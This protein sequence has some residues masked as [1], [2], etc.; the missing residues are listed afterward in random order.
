MSASV[1]VRDAERTVLGT[2]LLASLGHATL[3][4]PHPKH[5]VRP[6]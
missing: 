6:I 3:H 5:L 4:M 1:I 2:R